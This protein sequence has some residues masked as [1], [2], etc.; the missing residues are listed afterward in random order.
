MDVSCIYSTLSFLTVQAERL[1]VQMPCVTFDQPFMTDIFLY[2]YGKR[3]CNDGDKCMNIHKVQE[4]FGSDVCCQIVVLHVFDGCDTTSAIF[5]H[6][7][8]KCIKLNWAVNVCSWLHFCHAKS[9]CLSSCSEWSRSAV[10][11]FALRLI[12]SVI[13]IIH[14]TTS[15][16]WVITFR[17]KDCHFRRVQLIIMHCVSICR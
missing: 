3:K 2:S 10:A 4:K 5:G 6:G 16:C 17:L 1:N 13:C 9:W 14:I 7:K 11:G 12:L 15:Y 8:G